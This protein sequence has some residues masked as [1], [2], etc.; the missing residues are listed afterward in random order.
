MLLRALL[1]LGLFA[2]T[3][4]AAAPAASMS[5]TVAVYNFSLA[6]GAPSVP[7]SAASTAPPAG[8]PAAAPPAAPWWGRNFDPGAALSD[9]LTDRLTNLGKFSVVD[10]NHLAAVLKEQNISAEGDVTPATEAQL[11]RML[12]VGY[13]FIGKIEQFDQSAPGELGALNHMFSKL[14]GTT[15]STKTILS[16]SMQVINVNT[17][18][19]VESVE[20]SRT[21]QA[22]AYNVA[23]SGMNYGDQEFQASS[24]GKLMAAVADDLAKKVDAG[25]LTAKA[26]E[27][28]EGHVVGIDGDAIVLNI[29]SDKGATVGM[30]FTVASVKHLLDPDTKERITTE[31][32]HGSIQVTSVTKESSIAKKIS[33]SPRIRDVVRLQ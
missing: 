19:V 14:A 13:L 3:V 21:G 26:P 24:I 33:G 2:L 8:T 29:G 20:D 1:V 12:G 18:Q 23:G 27:P 5:P 30:M 9:L 32:P 25:K 16:V 6:G 22:S 4:P 11:G 7:A 15:S 31:I 28:L 17:G 10:R